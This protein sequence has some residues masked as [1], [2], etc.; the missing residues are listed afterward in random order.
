M[1]S[2]LDYVIFSQNED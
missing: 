2:Q 1:S